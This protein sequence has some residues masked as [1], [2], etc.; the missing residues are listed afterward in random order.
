MKVVHARGRTLV[1]ARSS[2]QINSDARGHA[3]CTR[4]EYYNIVCVRVRAS[5]KWRRPRRARARCGGAVLRC[6]AAVRDHGECHRRH[7]HQEGFAHTERECERTARELRVK[8][9]GVCVCVCVFLCVFLCVRMRRTRRRMG[10]YAKLDYNLCG[11][12]RHLRRI[13]ARAKTAHICT[14]PHSSLCSALVIG[15]Q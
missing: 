11:R 1:H 3:L 12:P 5:C 8:L 9:D 10:N 15:H 4:L 13:R 14:H 2:P 7:H 6:G